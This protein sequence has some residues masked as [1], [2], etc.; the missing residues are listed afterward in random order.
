MTFDLLIVYP[1]SHNTGYIAGEFDLNNDKGVFSTTTEYGKC[2]ITFKFTKF[3]VELNESGNAQECGFGGGVYAS[4]I[5]KH[6]DH[7]DPSFQGDPRF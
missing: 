3:K 2:E 4:R 6:V 5:L 7:G 1:R